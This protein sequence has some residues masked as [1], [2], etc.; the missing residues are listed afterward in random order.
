[1]L[2]AAP[3]SQAATVSI[4]WTKGRITGDTDVN[5]TGDLIAAYSLA[6]ASNV[7]LNTTT[8]T[9]VTGS[10]KTG[11]AGDGILSWSSLGDPNFA[12][13]NA[14]GYLAT[15]RREGLSSSYNDL[16]FQ[17]LSSSG[18]N[19]SSSQT[20]QFTFSNLVAGETYLVQF[21]TNNSREALPNATEL[22]FSNADDAG[23]SISAA[24]NHDKAVGSTGYWVTGVF[25]AESSQ[26]KIN[27]QGNQWMN[28]NALQLR[29]L[30]SPIPEPATTTLTALAVFG[31]AARRRR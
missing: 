20:F 29:H 21:W 6:G 11:S 15:D 16:L 13:G 5:T 12:P 3:L 25:T 8:F 19:A 22:V 26:Q 10:N 27:I 30:A 14:Q 4:D 18:T 9:T 1:M 31:L 2:A 17:G 28:I 24:R 23:N 7:T